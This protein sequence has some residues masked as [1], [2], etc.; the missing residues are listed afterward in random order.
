MNARSEIPLG[1]FYDVPIER[2]HAS[3]G[4]S[5]TGLR[6][7]ARSPR[8]F[9]ALHLDPARPPQQEKPGH[10]EGT[11]AHCAILEPD[12][13]ARRYV[14]GPDVSRVTKVWKEFE[15]ALPA[16]VTG[17]KPEQY[18]TALAQAR[19]VRALPQ[20][21]KL[22]GQGRPEVSSFWIDPATGELCRCRPDWVHPV[23]E[24]SVILVDVKT[25]S[26]ASPAEFG[27]QIAR[28]DYHG[29]AAFY[30]DGYEVASGR[31]VLGF[32]F[33]AV[34]A[35]WPYAASAVMV[36]D[37][38]LAKGRADN[39]QLLDL[40]ARCRAENSW[41]GYSDTIEVVSLPRWAA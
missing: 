24:R 17:V 11:L 35:D 27:R 10:L 32:V 29:Q 26:D 4:I 25:C 37:E 1:L 12:H 15:A 9:Y 5:N 8:H 19:A 36:D 18:E 2:Y 23:G 22:L 21:A 7:L 33:V 3:P 31:N 13:F 16:G 20:V 40:Y 14:A 28:K 39:R 6:D 30:T 41:P 34:E 38:S